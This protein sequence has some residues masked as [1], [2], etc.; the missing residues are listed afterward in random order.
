MVN[1]S[2]PW[3]NVTRADEVEVV[4]HRHRQ[5]RQYKGVSST[6]FLSSVTNH[7]R[8][9]PTPTEQHKAKKPPPL[10]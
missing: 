7:N 8:I 2:G 5:N 3:V 6:N 4:E 9:E 10:L 1:R